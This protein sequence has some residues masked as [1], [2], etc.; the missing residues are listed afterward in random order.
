MG[1]AVAWTCGGGV[2]VDDGLWQSSYAKGKIEYRLCRGITC[3]GTAA[4][5]ALRKRGRL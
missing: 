4:G 3:V 1:R 2:G 5:K